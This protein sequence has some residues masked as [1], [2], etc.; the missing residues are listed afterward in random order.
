[1]GVEIVTMEWES[2]GIGGFGW[3]VRG[4]IV[5]LAI[6]G[7]GCRNKRGRDLRCGRARNKRG[8][9]LRYGRVRVVELG[10]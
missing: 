5:E 6:N 10:A 2:R 1:M 8:R 4:W 7:E 3:E 9:D